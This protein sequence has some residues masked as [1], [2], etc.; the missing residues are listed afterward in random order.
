MT[1]EEGS[2]RRSDRHR[3]GLRQLHHPH[4][5]GDGVMVAAQQGTALAVT[6]DPDRLPQGMIAVQR[7]GAVGGDQFPAATGVIGIV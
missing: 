7:I 2:G 6:A 5:V 1:A 3:K 4:A